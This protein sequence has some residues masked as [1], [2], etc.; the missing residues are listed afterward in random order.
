MSPKKIYIPTLSDKQVDFEHLFS[1]VN[2]VKLSDNDILFNFSQC[3]SL[4]PNAIAL[5]GGIARLAQSQ[6]K[7]VVF[8]WDSLQNDTLNKILCQNGFAKIFGYP[9][10]MPLQEAIPYREDTILNM[11]PIMDYLT[12]FWIGKGWVHVSNA[13]RDAIVSRHS[14]AYYTSLR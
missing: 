12:E 1:M 4:R 9:S 7:K 14:G 11:N 10:Q 2:Q 6:G 3:Q 5:L 13:L 8:Q